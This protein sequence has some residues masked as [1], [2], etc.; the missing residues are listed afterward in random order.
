MFG[1][2]NTVRSSIDKMA[3]TQRRKSFPKIVLLFSSR[4]LRNRQQSEFLTG[5]SKQMS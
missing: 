2:G 3:Y 4:N 5:C 1:L